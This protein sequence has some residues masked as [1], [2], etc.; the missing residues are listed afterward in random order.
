MDVDATMITLSGTGTQPLKVRNRVQILRP[1]PVPNPPSRSPP[2]R[3]EQTDRKFD[4]APSSPD[5]QAGARGWETP[6]L[7]RGTRISRGRHR[8]SN[9][10]LRGKM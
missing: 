10:A 2:I 7:S 4:S 8:T 6:V 3:H 9:P 5:D 1:C